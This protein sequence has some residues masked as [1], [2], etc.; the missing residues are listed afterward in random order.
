MKLMSLKEWERHFLLDS[1]YVGLRC[2]YY[3]NMGNAD[4]AR[5]LAT[6]AA[7]LARMYQKAKGK[8]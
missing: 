2:R 4:L 6:E 7:H 1:E 3:I 8:Y 5:L